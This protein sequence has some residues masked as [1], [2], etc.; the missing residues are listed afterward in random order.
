MLASVLV[1][2]LVGLPPPLLL[3]SALAASHP[4]HHSTADMATQWILVLLLAALLINVVA[5]AVVILRERETSLP[6]DSRS[7]LCPDQ[8]AAAPARSPSRGNAPGNQ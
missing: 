4:E 3:A 1:R 8:D 7:D 5:S 6:A 2:A